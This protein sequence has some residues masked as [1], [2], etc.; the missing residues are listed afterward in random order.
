MGADRGLNFYGAVTVG[1]RGQIVIPAEA[2]RALSIEAGDKL[3]ILCLPSGQNL[4]IVKADD[5]LKFLSS[6]QETLSVAEVQPP[7]EEG[8][9]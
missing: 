9:E 2:R 5:M 8:E 6:M 3:L 4:M 7:A 1:E